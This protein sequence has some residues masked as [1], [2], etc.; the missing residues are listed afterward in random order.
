[1]KYIALFF[2][3]LVMTASVFATDCPTCGNPPPKTTFNAANC[4]TGA[5]NNSTLATVNLSG[6]GSA[7]MKAN[8]TAGV[9]NTSSQAMNPVEGGAKPTMGLTSQSFVGGNAS[10]ELTGAGTGASKYDGSVK[11]INTANQTAQV[12]DIGTVKMNGSIK[13]D[14][15]ASGEAGDNTAVDSGVESNAGL[16]S[17][18]IATNLGGVQTLGV[19]DIKGLQLGGS[20]NGGIA[21]GSTNINFNGRAY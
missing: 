20:A 7:L 21:T 2:V 11:S 17:Q 6:Q 14:L 5:V 4:I 15:K 9:L 16:S 8:S 18:G 12:K 13:T 3:L 10:S 19:Q 1:M